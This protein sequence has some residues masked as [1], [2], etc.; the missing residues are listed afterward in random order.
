VQLVCSHDITAQ[1]FHQWFQQ[2]AAFS[3]PTWPASSGPTQ[4]LRAHKSPTADTT[5]NDHRTWKRVHGPAVPVL[6]GRDRSGGSARLH[7]IPYSTA[8]GEHDE[9]P[10]PWNPFQHLGDIFPLLLQRAATVRARRWFRF[11]GLGRARQREIDLH[12]Y[13]TKTGKLPSASSTKVASPPR[14]SFDACR[15]LKTTNLALA[16][17]RH[18][19]VP[20][21]SLWVLRSAPPRVSRPT[22][23]VKWRRGRLQSQHRYQ[24]YW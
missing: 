19:S 7:H 11:A 2:P 18:K 24:A 22:L 9:G 17:L 6:P 8:W 20:R 13:G 14:S 1:N 5:A 23:A 10:G 21:I 15:L 4:P 12:F 16:A 3:P